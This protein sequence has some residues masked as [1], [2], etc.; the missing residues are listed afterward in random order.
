MPDRIP[1]FL[2]SIKKDVSALELKTEN[3]KEECEYILTLPPNTAYYTNKAESEMKK[4]EALIISAE[5]VVLSLRKTYEKYVNYFGWASGKYKEDIMNDFLVSELE[6]MDIKAGYTEE[7]WVYVRVPGFL[8]ARSEMWLSKNYYD[9]I[10]RKLKLLNPLGEKFNEKCF[11]VT[12]QNIE[13]GMVRP[14]KDTDNVEYK[15]LNNILAEAFLWDDNPHYSDY[16]FASLFKDCSYVEAFIIPIKDTPE[17]IK[18]LEKG[19]ITPEMLLEN[20]KNE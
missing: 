17:F 7:G 6:A 20:P 2:S 5:K 8:P 10:R 1:V 12:V 16:I 11:M 14:V 15:N 9:P 18:R 19:E 3:L 13:N 4:F